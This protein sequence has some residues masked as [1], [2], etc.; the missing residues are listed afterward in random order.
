MLTVDL[1]PQDLGR[2]RFADGPAPILETVLMLFELRQRPRVGPAPGRGGEWH[3]AA[4]SAF[5]TAG[6]PLLQL[7]PSREHAFLPDVLTP[8]AEEAFYPCGQRA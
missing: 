7:A 1:A 3:R 8:D 6:R 2:I 4:R 5:T